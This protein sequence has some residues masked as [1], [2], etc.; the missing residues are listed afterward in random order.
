M[1][2]IYILSNMEKENNMENQE[3]K[4][5]RSGIR[6]IHTICILLLCFMVVAILSGIYNLL[7]M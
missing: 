6:P 5:I 4:I 7:F 2:Y 1:S 3:F